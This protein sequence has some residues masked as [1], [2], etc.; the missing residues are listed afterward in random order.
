[1]ADD[2]LKGSLAPAVEESASEEPEL[3]EKGDEQKHPSKTFVEYYGSIVLFVI[4]IAI[5]SAIIFL[6]PIIR[7]IKQTNA[8][9]EQRILTIQDER[10]YLS[11]LEQSV[12]AARSIDPN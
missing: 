9:I 5:G 1:M 10:R 3:E 4:V 12:A 2:L 6:R 11:T 7:D 8:D